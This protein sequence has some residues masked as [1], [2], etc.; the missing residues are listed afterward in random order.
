MTESEIGGKGKHLKY[1]LV[2]ALFFYIPVEQEYKKT[3]RSLASK[4][5]F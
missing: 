2:I 4:T 1:K 3:G 5:P